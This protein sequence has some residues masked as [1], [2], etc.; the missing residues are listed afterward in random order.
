MD[1]W[2]VFFIVFKLLG[3]L[4]LLMFGMKALSDGLQKM[5]GPQMR[6]W[7]QRMTSNR[8]MGMIMGMTVT[9][10]IQSSTA[11][12]LMTV[13]FVNAGLLTLGQA[14]SVILGAHIGTT[15]T[16]WIMSAGFAGGEQVVEGIAN[17]IVDPGMVKFVYIAFF[18]GI[19]L[20]Y[21][22]KRKNFGDFLF[23]VGF[24][25]LGLGTLKQTGTDLHLEDNQAVIGFFGQFVGDNATIPYPLTVIIFLLI[26]TVMTLCVQS[27]AAI[28]AIV[29]TIC[30]TGAMPLELGIIMVLG[31]NI[32]TTI[33]SN[34]AALGANVSAR[35]TAFSHFMV[36]TLGVFWV[37]C[38]II[39]FKKM[40]FAI[41]GTETNALLVLPTFHSAFNIANT[42]IMIWFVPL[43]EKTVCKIIKPKPQA[44]DEDSRLNFISAG[45]MQTPE[46][47]ILNAKKEIGVFGERCQ[48]MFGFV[49]K[50]LH[51]ETGEEFNKLFSRIE[52]Y[53]SIT[54]KMEVEIAE[55]INQVIDGHLS[56]ESKTE[57]QR[58]LRVVSEMESI[59][60]ACYNLA[61][62]INRK[63]Q[64]SQDDFTDKQ[65]DNIDAMFDLVEEALA[66]MNIIIKFG[67]QRYVDINKS[68]NMEHE[69]NNYR[70]QLKNQNV[71]DINN[72]LYDYQIG[73]YYMDIISECEKLGDY[74]INV[75]ESSG[76]KEKK[77]T[78]F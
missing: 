78:G 37:L 27:S 32:G 44:E 7:L 1:F 29:M 63:R 67:E 55:Y 48:R 70:T 12:T 10:A 26:G 22:K 25:F 6:L 4:A 57:I 15:L 73:V 62:S 76:I 56:I 52:K 34:I 23:G 3:S 66:Q 45:L 28:M 49:R 39:P 51:M 24:L 69:I 16:A 53:E 75:I 41:A 9:A 60:D 36:N 47:S 5:A 11:T 54:D 68:Y 59:G 17:N 2:D 8:F 58:M 30:S 64:H 74:I 18:I 43:I 71:V 38:L 19:I 72:Q 61:R 65:Y 46:L 33:T 77:A 13:S 14:I 20:I 35:R 50:F 42:F 21:M 40:V 31:E